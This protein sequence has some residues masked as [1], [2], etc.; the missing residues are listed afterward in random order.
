MLADADID[1]IGYDF[2]RSGT[3]S[4]VCQQT[5]YPDEIERIWLA[6]QGAMDSGVRVT[7]SCADRWNDWWD[8]QGA[9]A[10]EWHARVHRVKRRTRAERILH[11]D[12]LHDC[13]VS[14]ATVWSRLRL[15]T[16]SKTA[17]SRRGRICGPSRGDEQTCGTDDVGAGATAD[18]G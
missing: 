7:T 3:T 2:T 12:L 6:G 17:R 11:P 14:R 15:C 9:A 8:G 4:P 16:W 10:P 1:K 5:R 13:S 18:R